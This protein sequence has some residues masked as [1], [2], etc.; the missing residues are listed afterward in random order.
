MDGRPEW[1]SLRFP[2]SLSTFG[3]SLSQCRM[4]LVKLARHRCAA[5]SPLFRESLEA[6]VD[7]AEHARARACDE[8][9]RGVHSSGS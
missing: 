7:A 1:S 9:V 2:P 5:N 6:N 3:R 8:L 4:G